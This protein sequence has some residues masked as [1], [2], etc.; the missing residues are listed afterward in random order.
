MG[1][2]P[3]SPKSP[4]NFSVGIILGMTSRTN[5]K[6]YDYEKIFKTWNYLYY[7][8]IGYYKYRYICS[9]GGA[10]DDSRVARWRLHRAQIY[11]H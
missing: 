4:H 1:I 10:K 2:S 5:Q 11:R 7:S 9:A 8:Y 3:E 6:F